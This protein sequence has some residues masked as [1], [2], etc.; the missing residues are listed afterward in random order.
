[1]M[2]ALFSFCAFSF[3]YICQ[4]FMS[5]THSLRRSFHHFHAWISFFGLIG[6]KSNIF[7]WKSNR[8]IAIFLRFEKFRE[9][10]WCK[11]GK[12]SSVSCDF[13]KFVN[14]KVKFLV[15]THYS[16]P[17][18]FSK[19]FREQT[20]FNCFE[21]RIHLLRRKAFYVLSPVPHSQKGF[22]FIHIL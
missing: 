8:S 15:S 14:S 22:H 16:R 11:S 19:K 20:W 2:F 21:S 9:N 12:A 4:S 3:Y 5:R 10:T 17:G 13:T 1:M 6:F 18:K 7:S